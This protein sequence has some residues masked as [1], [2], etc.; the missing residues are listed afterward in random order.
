MHFCW[1]WLSRDDDRDPREFREYVAFFEDEQ[2]RG[3][4]LTDFP[5]LQGSPLGPMGYYSYMAPK[6]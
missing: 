1:K 2:M 4:S 6:W 5:R 3:P